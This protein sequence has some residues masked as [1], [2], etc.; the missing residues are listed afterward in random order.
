MSSEEE[1]H[2]VKKYPQRCVVCGSNSKKA[3]YSAGRI[4]LAKK[5]QNAH[6]IKNKLCSGCYSRNKRELEKVCFYRSTFM[7]IKIKLIF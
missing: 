1:N 3:D 6:N 4:V 5:C 7:I 2:K